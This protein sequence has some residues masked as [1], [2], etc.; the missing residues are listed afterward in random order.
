MTYRLLI[1]TALLVLTGGAA[2]QQAQTTVDS[3]VLLKSQSSW[4]GT[5]YESYPEG[6]PELTLL[7]IKI[8]ANTALKWHSHPIPNAAYVVAGEITVEARDSKKR[9]HLKK[10]DALA[11]M[12][13]IV[14]RGQTGDMPVELIVFYAATAATPLSQ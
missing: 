8:P 2:A 4:D 5:P 6:R 3:R 9:I 14:H 10:G 11:E 1:A 12:V 13:D 7:N